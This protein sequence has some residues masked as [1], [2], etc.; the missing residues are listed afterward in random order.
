MYIW[1]ASPSSFMYVEQKIGE[2]QNFSLSTSLMDKIDFCKQKLKNKLRMC[3][4]FQLIQTR[5][6]LTFWFQFS[7]RFIQWLRRR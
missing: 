4:V 2:R 3:F 5:T 6:V 7:P 1:N